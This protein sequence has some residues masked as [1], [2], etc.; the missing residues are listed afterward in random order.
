MRT[1]RDS[2]DDSRL[3]GDVIAGAERYQAELAARVE[4]PRGR[5]PDPKTVT[6][7]DVSYVP[8]SPQ[9]AAGAVTV[10]VSSGQIVD[11]VVVHGEVSF[12]YRPGLLAFR[13]VP[14]LLDAV[15]RLRR[16]PDVIM[17]DGHGLAHPRRC[18]LA[19]HL[20]V[21]TGV[22][23]VGCAKSRFVGEH[24]E[25]GPRRGDRAA[26]QDGSELVGYAV[27]TQDGV[28]P[29][30][31]SPGHRVGLDQSCQIVLATTSRF[32]LPD[33]IR[34]ADQISRAALGERTFRYDGDCDAAQR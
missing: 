26:L 16:P 29:V 19:C 22:A 5:V 13:E 15:R 11:E 25:P 17:S 18:G 14:V 8:G 21:L 32:R 31:V 30:Y 3:G 34:R 9:V 7:V 10:E 20:G 12:P 23:A 2:D 28:R 24:P 27:R 1:S 33:P 4:V 6:G